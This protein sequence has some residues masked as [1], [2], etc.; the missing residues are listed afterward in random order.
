MNATLNDRRVLAIVT[1]YGVEQDELVVPVDHL[2]ERGATVVVAAPSND[3]IETLVGDKDPGKTVQPDTTAGA[4]DGASERT[5]ASG[6][7]ADQICP[8]LPAAGS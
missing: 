2:R 4:V 5:D 1:N 8:L 7:G 6:M 3:P